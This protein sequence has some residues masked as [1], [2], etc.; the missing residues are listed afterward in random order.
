MI[1]NLFNT[2]NVSLRSKSINHYRYT[3]T[4]FNNFND[5]INYL[6]KYPLKSQKYN[7]FLK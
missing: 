1:K 7:S 3:I 2:G 5:L 4:G 6:E